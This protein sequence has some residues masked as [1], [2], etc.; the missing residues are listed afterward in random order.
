MGAANSF[1][2]KKAKI[3]PKCYPLAERGNIVE[4]YHGIK[5]CFMI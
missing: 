1:C 4:E 2:S 5:V 3:K